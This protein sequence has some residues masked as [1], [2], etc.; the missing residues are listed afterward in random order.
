M[1]QPVGGRFL[2]AHVQGLQQAGEA[3]LFQG[4]FKCAHRQFW[5]EG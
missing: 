5:V 3:E 1:A 4:I 2:P